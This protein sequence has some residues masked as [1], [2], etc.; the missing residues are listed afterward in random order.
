MYVYACA[1]VN[2]WYSWGT[3][4]EIFWLGFISYS[5]RK[6]LRIWNGAEEKDDYKISCFRNSIMKFRRIA[7]ASASWSGRASAGSARISFD[8]KISSEIGTCHDPLWT[9]CSEIYSFFISINPALSLF[10]VWRSKHLKFLTV[11]TTCYNCAFWMN[12]CAKVSALITKDKCVLSKARN[13]S[14][15]WT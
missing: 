4:R 3:V 7:Q 15:I 10:P 12:D 13:S 14:Q 5:I 1:Y 11:C 6:H 2:S 8:K 9:I